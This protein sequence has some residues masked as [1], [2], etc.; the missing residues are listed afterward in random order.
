M[1]RAGRHFN[2]GCSREGRHFHFSTECGRDEIDRHITGD[3]EAFAMKD[4]MRSDGDG[5]VEVSGRTTI[6][7]M[8]SFIGQTKSHAGLDTGWNMDGDGALFVDPL[9]S[10]AGRTGIR[11]EVTGAFTLTARPADAEESLL[12]TKLPRALAATA[13]LDGCRRF[14]SSS[15]TV[16]ADF[17]ARNFEFGL[18]PVDGFLKRDF[19]VVLEIVAAFGPSCPA[20]SRLAEKVFENVVK[21]IP[22]SATIEIE[23]VKAWPTLLGTGMTE[24]VVAFPPFLIAQRFVG[25]VDFLKLLFGGFLLL[26]ADVEVRV[27]L[28]SQFPV[29]LFEVVFGHI[30]IDAESF[31]VI[32]FRHGHCICEKKSSEFAVTPRTRI[33]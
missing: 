20:A 31:V 15:F 9:A 32:A 5:H 30:P 25:F 14:C 28:A 27:V 1:L 33:L 26:L 17:P 22:K 24:H 4:L 29:S 10:L 13:W 7:A 2:D 8:F 19:E 6:R 3:I 21:Y 11:D 23:P 12:K 18:F 16:D